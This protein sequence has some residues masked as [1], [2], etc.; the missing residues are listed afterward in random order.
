M[1]PLWH[2]EKE[3]L[4]TYLQGEFRGILPGLSE[5]VQE[6]AKN[7]DLS[8]DITREHHSQMHIHFLREDDSFADP[9][10]IF[11]LLLE[12]ASRVGS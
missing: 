2:V 11:N 3:P 10:G 6:D 9:C 1:T 4:P 12:Q 5:W 7:F 8:K